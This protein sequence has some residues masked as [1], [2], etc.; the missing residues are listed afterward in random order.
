MM[1]SASRDALGKAAILYVSA[2]FAVLHIGFLSVPDVAFVFVIG[3]FF[4]WV[5][6]KTGS[7]LG[8]TLSHGITNI[9]LL[10]VR[11]LLL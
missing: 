3:L 5:V 6:M 9:G 4:A 8:V 2:V 1:Q 10:L 11:P 7:I